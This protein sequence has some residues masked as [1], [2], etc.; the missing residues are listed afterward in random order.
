MKLVI[1]SCLWFGIHCFGQQGGVQEI[2]EVTYTYTLDTF[3]AK[4]AW[5]GLNAEKIESLQANDAADLIQKLTSTN[6]R[7]YGGLGGLKTVSSRGLGANHSII[8]ADGFG[9]NNTQNGQVNLGQI[10]SDNISYIRSDSDEKT[11]FLQPIS[12]QVSGSHFSLETF[13]NNFGADG[14]QFRLQGKQGSFNQMGTYSAAKFSSKKV[15]LS[16]HGS[17]R[18]SDGNYPF[19]LT[20]GSQN[21][22]E[23][24]T[25]NDYLDYSFG[26]TGGFKF[27]NSVF[28][29]G[30]L[31]KEFDQGLPGA[32]ILYNNFTDERME[33]ID[34]NLFGDHVFKGKKTTFRSFFKMNKNQ[35]R[36]T[37][38]D[39]LGQD[40]GI[41]ITYQNE[42]LQLG[43][44]AEHIFKNDLKIH[45]GAEEV[46]SNLI[47]SDIGFSKP[48][49]MHH[50]GIVGLNYI[51]LKKY[52][53]TLQ[54]SEQFIEENNKAGVSAEN[55]FKINP[56]IAFSAKEG[57]H[58]FGHTIWYRN[59]FRMP[60]FNELYYN[61]IGNLN[62]EPEQAHQ[63]NYAWSF[64]SSNKRKFHFYLRNTFYLNF[65][66]EKIVAIPTKNLFTW[67]MQ[68]V[69]NVRILGGDLKF[70]SKFNTT[71]D[72]SFSLDLNY[73]NQNAIDIS[74]PNSPTFKNQIAYMPVH[75]GNIDLSIR[76]KDLGITISNYA[77]SL[78]YALNENITANQVNGFLISTLS[79]HYTLKLRNKNKLTFRFTVKNLFDSQYAVI[80]SFVMPGRNYIIVMKYA[81]N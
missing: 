30:Y 74:D 24:R 11:Q 68:N 56:Y 65:V 61:N 41:D 6:I 10:H 44:A 31:Q 81:F 33:R 66:D 40:N 23:T 46:L 45:F 1:I 13:E 73:S 59:S 76:Y 57:K 5:E 32:V 55:Q 4:N 26:F 25:N 50:F 54:L 70:G 17:I 21:S 58:K 64:S 78:R 42:S 53:L 16:A 79:S 7:S 19:T 9:I 36:Y 48:N 77:N 3:N 20:N 72:L 71:K 39:Y 27:G 14:F 69:E 47:V 51:F 12:A 38:P 2:N 37:D 29:L 49:R 18:K 34:Q 62:L 8:V 75:S 67:S 63:F 43:V 22:E 52:G 80:R 15:L 60:T 28:R 35:M